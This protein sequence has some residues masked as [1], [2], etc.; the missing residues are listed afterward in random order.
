MR[1]SCVSTN[2][3]VFRDTLGSWFKRRP[4]LLVLFRCPYS[5]GA[6]GFELFSSFQSLSE[7]IQEL[8]AET[9]VIVFREPQLP[10]RG[11]VDDQFIGRCL[12]TIPDNTEYLAVE[13][14]RQVHGERSWF[15]DYAGVSHAELRDDLEESRGMPV[16]VGP[17][18]SWN[19]DHH[20]AICA[21]VP[22]RHSGAKL[23]DLI[24]KPKWQP[25][26]V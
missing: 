1:T 2:D 7:R 19:E 26:P 25:A 8:P 15:H 16:A 24:V 11:V 12:A 4:D 10:L 5:A 14:V 13:T 20:E 6:K 18:P 23:Y 9:S 3:P 21:V 22:E 17:Y